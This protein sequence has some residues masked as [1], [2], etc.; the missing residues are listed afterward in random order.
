LCHLLRD[1]AKLRDALGVKI[2]LVAEGH[3]FQ[4]ENGFTRLVH[5]FD[6]VFETRRGSGRAK[7]TAAIYDNCDTCWNGCTAN[8][9]DKSGSLRSLLSDTNCSTL[10]SQTFIA[11]VDI[12]TPRGEIKTSLE[13]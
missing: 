1:E 8:P 2:V 13:A 6:C 3:R 10:A 5:R 4:C 7:M 9:G 12:V 11:D